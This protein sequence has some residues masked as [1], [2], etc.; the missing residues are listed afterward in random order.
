MSQLTII[1]KT[2]PTP[3][4]VHINR[5]LTN[6][7]V[8]HAQDI[9]PQFFVADQ[10]FPSIP[11]SNQSDLYWEYPRGHFN[12]NNMRKR[13]PGAETQKMGY[14]VNADGSFFCHVWGIHIDV[15]DQQVA[16][17]D[18]PLN[19]FMDAARILTVQ[20]LINR[21]SEWA[22]AFFGSGIWTTQYTGLAA[23]PVPGTSFLQWSDPNSDFL[24]DIERGKFTVAGLAGSMFEPNTLVVDRRTWG[25]I[26]NHPQVVQRILYGNNGA[27]AVVSKLAVAALLEIDRV[28]VAGG[29]VN[30]GIEGAADSHNFI[31]P[32]GA[33]LAYVNPNP[34]L[35]APSA[36]YGF[37]WTGYMGA[38]SIGTRVR[39]FRDEKTASE[40]VE[41][42]AAYG[43]KK[44]S[45][46]LGVFFINPIA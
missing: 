35:M 4:D 37:N 9:G 10:V 22:T 40:R 46:D 8:A 16:N 20:G 36:G 12:R 5:P 14:G 45:A 33:F 27:P 41:L 34:G 32:E 29:V 31:I 23:A 42:E 6:V 17:S 15:T 2:Q 18:L 11:S 3:G 7:S 28:L 21:D 19:P 38:S 39:R 30:S 1:R 43:L 25:F 26:K 44:I 13:A 24:G